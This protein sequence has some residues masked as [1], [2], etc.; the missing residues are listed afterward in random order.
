[1]GYVTYKQDVVSAW[2]YGT[3]NSFACYAAYH[4]LHHVSDCA[5]TVCNIYSRYICDKHLSIS[6]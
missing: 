3:V 4:I 5:Y 6:R 1:M 2:L